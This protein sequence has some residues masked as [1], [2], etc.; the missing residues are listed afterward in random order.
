MLTLVPSSLSANSSFSVCKAT[1]QEFSSY[2][3]VWWVLQSY[4]ITQ[5]RFCSSV[6]L[7]DRHS[8]F[9]DKY[10]HKRIGRAESQVLCHTTLWGLLRLLSVVL[11]DIWGKLEIQDR[12]DAQ[13]CLVS[14]RISPMRHMSRIPAC[15]R[16]GQ[17]DHEFKANMS[18]LVSSKLA[19]V[20]ITRWCQQTNKYIHI[21]KSSVGVCCLHVVRVFV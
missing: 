10:P 9:R 19:W 4:S 14:R 18:Y 2:E 15:G 11:W 12:T 16:L 6:S 17:E 1:R 5:S 8:C 13:R 21:F 3:W 7:G 20:K